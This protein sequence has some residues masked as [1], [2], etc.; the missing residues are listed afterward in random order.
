MTAEES[1]MRSAL[2]Q[3]RDFAALANPPPKR[4][5]FVHDQATIDIA[6][7][8]ADDLLKKLKAAFPDLVEEEALR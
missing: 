7:A 4:E 3:L 2:E 5:L 8:E 1:I 6:E